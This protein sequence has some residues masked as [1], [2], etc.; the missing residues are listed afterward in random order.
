MLGIGQILPL[1][2]HHIGSGQFEAIIADHT[3]VYDL[4][5]EKVPLVSLL[6]KSRPMVAL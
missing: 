4:P 6:K 1:P 3:E 2:G 5:L